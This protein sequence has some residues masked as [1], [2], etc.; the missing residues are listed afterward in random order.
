MDDTDTGPSMRAPA[1]PE[2]SERAADA[3][4]VGTQLADAKRA[5]KPR[6]EEG[7]TS[8]AKPPGPVLW[9]FEAGRG[10]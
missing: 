5:D 4:S 1:E 8:V 6:R 9:N 7:Q 2:N 3:G 10:R